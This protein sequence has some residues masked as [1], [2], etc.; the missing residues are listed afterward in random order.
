MLQQSLKLQQCKTYFFF[1][2]TPK[3][4][5]KK[6]DPCRFISLSTVEISAFELQ[7]LQEQSK[8]LKEYQK[9]AG[10]QFVQ[11]QNL[12]KSVANLNIANAQLQQRSKETIERMKMAREEVNF[13]VDR[14]K[15]LLE[16]NEALTRK[17][18]LLKE[19]IRLTKEKYDLLL[20]EANATSLNRNAWIV[21]IPAHLCMTNKNTTR[22]V[23]IEFLK[24]ILK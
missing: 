6:I 19:N 22:K 11:L 16:M 10:D 5:T 23:P 18:D 3:K 21:H 4:K 24:N 17:N 13:V 15:E 20:Q 1:F 9:L 7:I 2:K 12:T 8:T 14:M